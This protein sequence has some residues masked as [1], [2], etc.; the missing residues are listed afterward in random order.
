MDAFY[1]E[2]VVLF[3]HIVIGQETLEFG[4]LWHEDHRDKAIS[5]LHLY[6]GETFL[7][8]LDGALTQI[9]GLLSN[10]T[11][12][13]VAE[14]PNAGATER[15]SIEFTTLAK[16]MPDVEITNTEKGQESLQLAIGVTDTDA[17]GAITKVELL[18]GAEV[19]TLP[20]T[21]EQKLADLLSELEQECEEFTYLGSY[22]EVI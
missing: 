13:L 14:Y 5:A 16:A 20:N 8:D 18:R 17:V 3:D 12:I 4:F 7:T 9:D 10:V 22:S 2:A 11:Y 19:K 15:I 6:R 1:T 21:T